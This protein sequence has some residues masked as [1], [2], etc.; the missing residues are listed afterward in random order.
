MPEYPTD[1]LIT[2]QELCSATGIDRYCLRRL[3]R[4]LGL[5]VF[6]TFRGRRGSESRYRVDRGPNDPAVP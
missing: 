4:W 6:R 5:E 3:R 2:E 1:D